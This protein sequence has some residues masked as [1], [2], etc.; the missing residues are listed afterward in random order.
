MK[1]YLKEWKLKNPNYFKEYYIK[2]KEKLNNYHDEWIKKNNET[3]RKYQRDYHR[4][5]YIEKRLKEMNKKVEAF[6][7]SLSNI[8]GDSKR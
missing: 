2:N 5:Y 6:K 7:L 8:N 1:E 3:N 4:K